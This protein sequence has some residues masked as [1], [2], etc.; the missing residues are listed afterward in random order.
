MPYWIKGLNSPFDANMIL[1]EGNFLYAINRPLLLRLDTE[2]G[3][4]KWVRHPPT[5]E[6]KLDHA[7]VGGGLLVSNAGRFVYFDAQ[8]NGVPIAWTAAV[9]SP[10]DIGLQQT[11]PFE[12]NQ[13]NRCNC[14]RPNF[15]GWET[16][17]LWKT[18]FPTAAGHLCISW[19]SEEIHASPHSRVF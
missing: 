17:S 18:A 10:E 19:R 15:A 7:T 5:G 13:L 16:S 3:E 11:D 2:S 12:T 9:S 14:A 4:V 8:G 1:G 6:V